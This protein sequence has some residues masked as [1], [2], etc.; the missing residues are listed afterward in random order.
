MSPIQAARL[1]AVR[2]SPMLPT[3][4]VAITA[5]MPGTPLTWAAELAL[6][7]KHDEPVIELV[8]LCLQPC[9]LFGERRQ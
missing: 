5:P 6:P 2:A 1:A 3:S 7:A 8:P 4:A 9:Q